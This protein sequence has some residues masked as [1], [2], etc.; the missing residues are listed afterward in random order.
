MSQ[1]TGC[2]YQV[3][4]FY[5]GFSMMLEATTGWLAETPFVLN[6]YFSPHRLR[7][8]LTRIRSRAEQL[9]VANRPRF[10]CYPQVPT[11]A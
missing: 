7:L 9:I 8:A 2:R 1:T 4:F 5:H 6:L 11:G 10:G 3:K